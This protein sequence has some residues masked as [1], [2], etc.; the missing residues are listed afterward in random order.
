VELIK[1]GE[2]ARRS[3]VPIATLKHYLREGLIQPARKTGRTM[4]WYDASVA[5]RVRTIKRLQHDQ[6]LPLDLIRKAVDEAGAATDDLAA[7]EAIATVLEE[8]GGTRSRTR[9]ELLERGVSEQE[10]QWLAA[11]K[12][13]VPTGPHHSYAGDDLALL[14]TLG[15]ARQ[16]GLSAEMLPF[17]ILGEYLQA[18]RTLVDVELRMFRAGVLPRASS[19]TTALTDA[20]TRLSERLVVLLRRKLLLPTLHRLIEE[21]H[22]A[23]K[24]DARARRPRRLRKLAA[25]RPRRRTT[26][27]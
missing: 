19:K 18:L 26:K 12:L 23:P 25:A 24:P 13:A 11:A 7:A 3:G 21:T 27:H 10:L 2:L 6:F 20:A 5:T 15:A 8:H 16:A 17:A 14:V 1:I 9:A 4:S 22:V